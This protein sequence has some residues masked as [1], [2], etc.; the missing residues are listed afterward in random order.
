MIR[1][2][3]QV[4]SGRIRIMNYRGLLEETEELAWYS[5]RG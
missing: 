5:I 1:I 4:I 2:S 3:S